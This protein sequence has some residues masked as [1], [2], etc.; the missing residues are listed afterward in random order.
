MTTRSLVHA[1][2]W[3]RYR[4]AVTE[5]PNLYFWVAFTIL[6]GLLFLPSYLYNLD[7][8]TFLPLEVNAAQPDQV[9][10][11]LLIWRNNLDIFRLNAEISILIALWLLLPWER[12]RFQRRL[13]QAIVAITYSFALAYAIYESLV[14]YLYQEEAVFYAHIIL[15]VD[16]LDFLIKH[17]PFQIGLLPVAALAVTMS[18]AALLLLLRTAM[19]GIISRR[20]SRWTKAV[21]A[22]FALFSL[23]ALLRFGDGLASPKSV[24][25]SLA[26]KL[27]Q[28]AA[29]SIALY[30]QV[31]TMDQLSSGQFQEYD[32]GSYELLAKPDIYLIFVE[33]YGSVLYDKPVFEEEYT[34]LLAVLENE[35]RQE[36]WQAAS[37]L[38]ESPSWGGGSWMAYTSALFGLR[39]DSHPQYL[40]LLER[41]QDE[42][43]P[44]LGYS[45][46]SK[47]YAY[48]RATSIAAEMPDEEWQKY[49][50]F[51]GVDRWLRYRDL[52][53]KGM[54][55]GWGPA[56]P[57]Q[58]VL[59][60]LHEELNEDE[61]PFLLFWITQNSH[62]PWRSLPRV[63]DDWRAL[64]DGNA[65]VTVFAEDEVAQETRYDNYFQ[66]ISYELS[67]LTDFIQRSADEDAIFV[68]IGDHQPGYITRRSDGYETP[69]HIISKDQSFLDRFSSFGFEPGL[70]VTNS[71]A[72]MRHEGFYSLFMR[73]LVAE[74]GSGSRQLPP[75]F[76]E[77][78]QLDTMTAG[79]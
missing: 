6:N 20:L 1:R 10:R 28:N 68:L 61:R 19:D 64:N 75:Y 74:Y 58:Y 40:A 55:Y 34:R 57:D 66:A 7:E 31:G 54:H 8:S 72:A 32:Y 26:M 22:A 46:R 71:Q 14:L 5:H 24:V 15:L 79:S 41:F 56:P 63:V 11:Q 38:S 33:S 48:V 70:V 39:V 16:G 62:Y 67:F 9:A 47:G 23:L 12:T 35:L 78:L 65:V 27:K 17:L 44:D 30:E 13:F 50:N 18:I 37:T 59:N 29:A 52:G 36:G 49:V 77:G 4:L 53:Y 25:S 2:A 60:A 73:A 76:P 42:S 3:T 43:F 69:V 45:L 21:M 51:F